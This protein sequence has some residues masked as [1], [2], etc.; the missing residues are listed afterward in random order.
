[1]YFNMDLYFKAELMELI[2]NNSKT[3][4]CDKNLLA[5]TFRR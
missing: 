1:L 5:E 2:I 3:D 4:D